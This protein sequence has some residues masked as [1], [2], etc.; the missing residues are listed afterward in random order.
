MYLFLMWQGR[1]VTKGKESFTPVEAAKV[2]ALATIGALVL[3]PFHL[4]A[5]KLVY[6]KI[7]ASIGIKK[8]CFGDNPSQCTLFV[9]RK[10]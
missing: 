6:S 8:V 3:L 9:D 7:L 1:D 2:W 10:I 5:Q 4:L